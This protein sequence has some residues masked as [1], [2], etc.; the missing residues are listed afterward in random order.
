MTFQRLKEILAAIEEQHPNINDYEIIFPITT[1]IMSI[2]G[3]LIFSEI[4][5]FKFCNSKCLCI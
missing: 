5:I 4:V 1:N 2:L 3:I